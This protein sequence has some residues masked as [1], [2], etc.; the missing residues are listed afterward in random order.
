M[1]ICSRRRSE[2][3][4]RAGCRT[5]ASKAFANLKCRFQII[6]R[7]V[8]ILEGWQTHTRLTNLKKVLLYWNL[9]YRLQVTIRNG[10]LKSAFYIVRERRSE[11]EQYRYAQVSELR[12]LP[13]RKAKCIRRCMIVVSWSERRAIAEAF[14]LALWLARRLVR[15]PS[16]RLPC[17]NHDTSISLAQR[18]LL[19]VGDI[20]FF[21]ASVRDFIQFLI[22]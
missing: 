17:R 13:H 10:L 5:P 22:F 18:G 12:V 6:D 19:S 21:H 2:G 14:G 1:E 9:N 8:Q 11:C 15:W 3:I 4:R 20:W 16:E 7:K